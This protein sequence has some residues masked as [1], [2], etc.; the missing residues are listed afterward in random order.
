[1]AALFFYNNPAGAKTIWEDLA[2]GK[3]DHLNSL[4][5]DR[6]FFQTIVEPIMTDEF[7]ALK[8]AAGLIGSGLEVLGFD[9]EMSTDHHWGQETYFIRRLLTFMCGNS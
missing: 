8:Y 9:D 1:L 4:D 3:Q 7:P 6:V 2:G 5:L